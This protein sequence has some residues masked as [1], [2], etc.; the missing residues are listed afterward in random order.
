MHT[1]L[2][3]ISFSRSLMN[4]EFVIMCQNI[5]AVIDDSEHNIRCD[6]FE[7]SLAMFKMHLSILDLI[8]PPEGEHRL[9]VPIMQK[10]EERR[11][12]AR[13]IFYRAKS[14]CLSINAEKKEIARR[15]MHWYGFYVDSFLKGGRDE[16]T[17]RVNQ[18]ARDIEINDNIKYY[19]EYLGIKNEIDDLI[20]INPEINKLSAERVINIAEKKSFRV[21]SVQVRKEASV[22]LRFLLRDI[23]RQI[24]S[25][26]IEVASHMVNGILEVLNRA[27]TIQK[28]KNTMMKKKKSKVIATAKDAAKNVDNKGEYNSSEE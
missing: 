23:E 12:A 4:S 6:L 10:A 22:A 14:A 19:I 16:V 2:S 24:Y 3:Q 11:D 15:F 28:R 9:T 27:R 13:I 26:G 25:N 1:T 5:V 21:D 8:M 18:L 7:E 17:A 20:N